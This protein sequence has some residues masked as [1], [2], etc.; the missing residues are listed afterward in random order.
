VAEAIQSGRYLAGGCTVLPDE[1]VP[2]GVQ[3]LVA[4]WNFLSR[5]AKLMAGSFI[6]CEAPAYHEVGGFS[7]ELFASEEIDLSQKLKKLARR[8]GKRLIIF[9]RHPI[10]TSARKLHLYSWKEHTRFFFRN[11]F[12]LGR[13]LKSREEC[14]TWYD[15]RR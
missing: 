9:H 13:S 14:F 1:K 11:M 12:R 3:T 4:G 15:G 7:M 2:R 8:R 10:L 5:T 6:F